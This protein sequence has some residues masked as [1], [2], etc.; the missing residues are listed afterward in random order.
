MSKGDVKV[1]LPTNLLSASKQLG[2]EVPPRHHNPTLLRQQ[3]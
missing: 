3:S 1:A 2:L